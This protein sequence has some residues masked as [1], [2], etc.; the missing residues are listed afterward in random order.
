MF[1]LKLALLLT[2]AFFLM[3][4]ASSR[5]VNSSGDKTVD[6]D[7]SG[8]MICRTSLSIIEK[9]LKR[10]DG[11]EKIEI[12]RENKVAHVTIDDSLTSLAKLENALSKAGFKANDKE[13]DLMGY[14]DLPDC[15]KIR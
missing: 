10:I 2:F 9:T 15:C 13:P 1:K 11:V 6:I 8:N 12:D 3:T 4:G 14:E 5:A 7:L